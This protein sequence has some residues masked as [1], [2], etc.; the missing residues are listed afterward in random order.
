MYLLIERGMKLHLKKKIDFHSPQDSLCQVW[1]KM[2]L[3]KK[4]LKTQQFAFLF[5]YKDLA[6]S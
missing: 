2:V 1:L 3:W 6:L 4:I 5:A